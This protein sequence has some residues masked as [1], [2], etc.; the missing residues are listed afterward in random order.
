MTYEQR[1]E[2][3]AWRALKLAAFTESA[4]KAGFTVEQSEFLFK[5]QERA[6]SGLGFLGLL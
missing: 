5:L 4:V 3:D 6:A 2:C 1:G